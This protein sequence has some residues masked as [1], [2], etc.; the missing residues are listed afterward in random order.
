MDLNKWIKELNIWMHNLQFTVET[1]E[2]EGLTILK[3]L[4][5]LLYVAVNW[6]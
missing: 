6:N 1:D 3:S 4:G 5:E 2:S